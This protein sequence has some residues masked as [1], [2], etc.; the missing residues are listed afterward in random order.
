MNPTSHPEA[1][2]TLVEALVATAI[3]VSVTAAVL[4][5]LNPARGAFRI[6]P[7]VADMQQRLRTGVDTLA[8]D[9]VTAGA[10]T[11][12]GAGPGSLVGYFAPILPFRRGLDPAI[13]DGAGVFKGD[14]ITVLYVPPGGAQTTVRSDMSTASSL[15]AINA[16][17][18]C[19]KDARTGL[20]DPLCGFQPTIT[21]GILFDGTGAFD[22][23]RITS[24]DAISQTLDFQSAGHGALSKAYPGST[25]DR[26]SR[27]V[28]ISSHVYF[29]NSETRQLMHY[30][31]FSTVT[32]V[33]DNV[34]GLEFEHFADPSPPAFVRP[35]KDQTVT[36]GPSPPKQDVAQAP[37]SP[38]ENCTWQV[39][40]GVQV[41]R[42]A[43]LGGGGGLVKLT[44]S[45]LTDG[46]W[47]PDDANVNRYDAD[48]LRI[49][50]V[51]VML[52]VQSG[53]ESMRGSLASGNNAMFVIRGTAASRSHTV[54][55]RSVR[56][57]VSPRNLNLGR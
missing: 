45:Q 5:A 52:R 15:I 19:P 41:S 33:V 7:E 25:S 49:R 10:G 21:K 54:P 2:F 55:D 48:L 51:R 42:L 43:F 22:M 17:P 47:C 57:D 39:S 26:L 27:I 20:M 14:A 32:P 1:G 11:S 38:G 35:G 6:Q 34:V 12:F 18:A 50:K 3:V 9:L 24:A 46:P 28:E 53:N 16:E 30:D 23:L 37:F 44:G 29:V 31:G 4:S 40:G 56:F 13:D 8:H 36:Y